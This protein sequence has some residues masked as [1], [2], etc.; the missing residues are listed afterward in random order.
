MD[1]RAFSENNKSRFTVGE[2][3][4]YD[5]TDM[6]YEEIENDDEQ[7]N[8]N[9][10]T[11]VTEAQIKRDEI[12]TDSIAETVKERGICKII[13]S[14]KKD[15]EHEQ[16]IEDC[17]DNW[18]L[19]SFRT[20]DLD[21]YFVEKYHKLIKW[22]VFLKGNMNIKYIKKYYA[23]ITDHT[24]WNS[25]FEKLDVNYEFLHYFLN[26]LNWKKFKIE[27]RM[28]LDYECIKL[29][30]NFV[31]WD[32]I[33]WSYTLDENFIRTNQSRVNWS[34]VCSHQKLTEEFIVEMH[35]RVNWQNVSI[36]QVLTEKFILANKL[37]LDLQMVSRHQVLTEKFI[38]DNIDTMDLS[39]LEILTKHQGFTID[40]LYKH[41]NVF[42]TMDV[43]NLTSRFPDTINFLTLF[44]KNPHEESPLQ[45]INLP[46]LDTTEP[47]QHQAQPWLNIFAGGLHGAGGFNG[48]FNNMPP[49]VFDPLVQDDVDTPTPS[50]SPPPANQQFFNIPLLP[51]LQNDQ[52]DFEAGQG[53]VNF[54]GGFHVMGGYNANDNFADVNDN[55]DF[56]PN[57]VDLDFLHPVEDNE[58]NAEL[59]DD[60]ENVE[61]VY[62]QYDEDIELTDHIMPREYMERIA[63]IGLD[64]VYTD[65]VNNPPIN[66]RRGLG[67]NGVDL[68][69][70][71]KEGNF[72]ET[73]I[74]NRFVENENAFETQNFEHMPID[75][76]GITYE[77]NL[78]E[79]NTDVALD[80]KIV[81]LKTE[82]LI[83][84]RDAV[85]N[86]KNNIIIE[87]VVEEDNDILNVFETEY[88][89]VEYQNVEY[90]IGPALP[91]PEPYQSQ[92]ATE[93]INIQKYNAQS[94]WDVVI[95]DT[96]V[97]EDLDTNLQWNGIIQE[98]SNDDTVAVL[99]SQFVLL[100]ALNV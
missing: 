15:L 64:A 48:A 87:D 89:N 27:R 65:A 75:D 35:D 34:N 53:P 55:D 92:P 63:E 66:P 62:E 88:Q 17:H 46:T 4:G 98:A 96:D 1:L 36:H 93:P 5:P 7:K 40:F 97:V 59:E 28:K 94:V 41:K 74:D 26:I 43:V 49:V 54:D 33:S 81:S 39:I 37:R 32:Y 68:D 11:I 14:Y 23:D 78:S 72:N 77:Y 25:I 42:L 9:D 18:T 76:F 56:D 51:Q 2:V 47:L 8:N 6:L 85:D 45:E 61:N 16:I 91:L 83:Q 12:N 10:I 3:L 31:D 52:Y 38:E 79:K 69:A 70:Y 99:E 29:M 86:I 19:I 84:D 44:L 21:E 50:P 100:T 57:D 20:F 30:K 58:V 82:Q 80:V 22:G 95:P 73:D 24:V 90:E 71:V 67:Q 60:R 13:L